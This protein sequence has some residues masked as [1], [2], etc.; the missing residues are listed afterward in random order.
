[1]SVMM[2]TKGKAMLNTITGPDIFTVSHFE[3]VG[4]TSKYFMC[5]KGLLAE[6]GKDTQIYYVRLV[7]SYQDFI[8]R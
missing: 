7:N 8:Y 5:R 3:R 4:E 1:M 2:S 6:D